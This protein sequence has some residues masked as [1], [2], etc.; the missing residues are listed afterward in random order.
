MYPGD[1]RFEFIQITFFRDIMPCGLVKR[2]N[3]FR[4]LL[5]PS[6]GQK[7]GA[8]GSSETSLT[9]FQITR[10]HMS[11]FSNLHIFSLQ[12]IRPERDYEIVLYQFQV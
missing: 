4:N 5:P 9:Y 8:A 11:E 12:A 7:I 3:F 10:R 1:S 2:I 6:S